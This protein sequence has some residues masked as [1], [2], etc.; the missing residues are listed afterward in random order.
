[1]AAIFGIR[2]YSIRPNI[3]VVHFPSLLVSRQDGSSKSDGRQF[4]LKN[5]LKGHQGAVYTVQYSPDGKY[6][7][8]GSF[9]KTVRIW[10]GATNQNEVK[11]IQSLALFLLSRHNALHCL[12]ISA[13]PCTLRSGQLITL[14]HC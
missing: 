4:Y 12:M 14:F 1:M 5:D 13:H 11:H 8:T 6:L 9:D 10:D 7:A 3:D 2:T